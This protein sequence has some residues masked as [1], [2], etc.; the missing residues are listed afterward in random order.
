[1]GSFWRGCDGLVYFGPGHL[2]LGQ[3]A[4][5]GNSDPVAASSRSSLT[6]P[7]EAFPIRTPYPE[8]P[9][10]KPH[11]LSGHFSHCPKIPQ[12]VQVRVQVRFHV[13]LDTVAH[14]RHCYL[15]AKGKRNA[16]FLSFGRPSQHGCCLGFYFR[17]PYSTVRAT[18]LFRAN[19]LRMETKREYL[20]LTL[21]GKY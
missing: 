8:V 5:T 7:V 13:R 14:R 3:L 19:K 21:I 9:F 18:D 2:E 11:H 1:M 16:P 10:Q 17:R 4:L 6:L 15:Q 12:I 20:L